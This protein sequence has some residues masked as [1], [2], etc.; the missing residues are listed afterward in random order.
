MDHFYVYQWRRP[1]TGAIFYVGKGCFVRDAQPKK[2]NKIVTRIVA[3]LERMGMAPEVERVQSG[4][5]EREAFEIERREIAKYG[6]INNGTGTLA[7]MTDGGEGTSGVIRSMETRAKLSISLMGNTNTIGRTLSSESRAKIGATKVGNT[8]FLGK[9][10]SDEARAKIADGARGNTNMLGKSHSAE[11]RM[12]MSAAATGKSPS[13]ETRAKLSAA[14]IGKVNSP[15]TRAKISMANKGKNKPPISEGHREKLSNAKRMAP[16]RTGF[17]GVCFI[18]ARGTWRAMLS[19]G[20][21]QLYLGAYAAEEEAA[22]AYD[23][24]AIAAWGLGACY[25]NFPRE[26]A[27]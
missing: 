9:Q 23:A 14:N 20:G 25:L 18:E 15:K 5:T 1:D 6:R 8:Y 22:R 27:A 24:G 4:L 16:P 19:V 21:D 7:N 17:K 26:V 11:S 12:K 10:H 13:E 2:H 3:K